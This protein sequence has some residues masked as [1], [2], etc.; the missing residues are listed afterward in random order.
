MAGESSSGPPGA[1][2]DG[3]KL[4]DGRKAALSG[5]ADERP[6]TILAAPTE[7]AK[8]VRR[9]VQESAGEAA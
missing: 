2:R 7:V 8:L 1:G 5:L 6:G 3:F 9:K 4:G